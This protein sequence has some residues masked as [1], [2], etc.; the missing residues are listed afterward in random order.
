MSRRES[1]DHFRSSVD[2]LALIQGQF[3]H[4]QA[5]PINPDSRPFLDA[6]QGMSIPV[7]VLSNIDRTDVEAAIA[8]HELR[9][10]GGSPA[11]TPERINRIRRC[12]ASVWS[13]SN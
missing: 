4:W 6:L 1:V 2:A 11:T 13:C 10:R 9:F 3:D 5:P 12:S 8:F 7:C